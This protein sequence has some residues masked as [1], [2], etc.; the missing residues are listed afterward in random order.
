MRNTPPIDWKLP[1]A[2]LLLSAIPLAAGMVRLAGLAS[3]SEI[4]AENARFVAAPL[5]VLLHL[6][7]VSLFSVLG[8]W[9][10][11]TAL[12]QR[13]PQWHRVS[14]RLVAASGVLSALTGLWMTVM[15]PIPPELQGGLLYGVRLAVGLAMVASIALAVVAV[16]RGD[17]V[18]HRGIVAN[19]IGVHRSR[20]NNNVTG[21]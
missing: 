17:L 18:N 1:L 9:Q 7:G 6:I 19:E 16:L 20:H 8:A 4:N 15:Y 5:P 21:R 3:H 11:S 13:H 14:G 2:L 10:F 12:R